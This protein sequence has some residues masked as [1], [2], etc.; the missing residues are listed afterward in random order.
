[1]KMKIVEASLI[2]PCTSRSCHN[3]KYKLPYQI[4]SQHLSFFFHVISRAFWV[5]TWHRL[6]CSDISYI[7]VMWLISDASIVKVVHKFTATFQ[8]TRTYVTK[9]CNANFTQLS[10]R[11]KGSFRL[12]EELTQGHLLASKNRH[13]CGICCVCS[14]FNRKGGDYLTE[15]AENARKWCQFRWQF[16]GSRDTL[17]L[18]FSFEPFL[19][20][21]YSIHFHSPPHS[22]IYWTIKLL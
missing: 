6:Q 19:S 16:Y 3:I 7:T 12:D 21:L 9:L 15:W 17:S 10:H 5:M 13:L 18:F 14:R 11:K 4:N 8:S 22:T 20:M 2:A 1:M